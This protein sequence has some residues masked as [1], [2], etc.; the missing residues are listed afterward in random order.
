MKKN[1]G[2]FISIAA[3]AFLL[4][5]FFITWISS[6]YSFQKNASK[7]LKHSAEL[8]TL[9]F[10]SKLNSELALVRQMAR[11][12]SICQYL[13]HPDNEELRAAAYE[14]FGAYCNSFL[15]KT[16]FWVSDANLE[17]YSDMQYQY[18]V[19]PDDPDSYWYKMTM[20]ETEE[21]NFNINYNPDLNV[22][23]LW[24]NAVI[25][26]SR[27]TPVGITGTG[28]PL[29]DFINSMY[30]GLD[31]KIVMFLYNDNL[32]ITGAQDSSLVAK[33]TKLLEQLPDLSKFDL[34]PT[35]I[36]ACNTMKNEYM[37]APLSLINWHMAMKI[38]FSPKQ[39]FLHALTP[40]AVCFSILLILF[41][42]YVSSKLVSNITVLK[43]AA[44]ELSSGNADLTKR[45]K[46]A[47]NSSI[48][49][50]NLLV[51]S[52]NTFIEKLQGIVSSVKDTNV[53]LVSSGEKLKAGMEDTET[54]IS[55]IVADIQTIGENIEKQSSCVDQT[56]GA[57]NQ[58]SGNIQSLNKM[59]DTQ[60]NSVNEASAAVEQMVGNI[61]SVN[62]I[63]E[64]LA[65]QF[66]D[67][68]DKTVKSVSKQEQVNGMIIKIQ[69][70]SQMLQDANL[71][72][73]SIADQTNLLAMNAAIEAAHAGE[74]GKGFSVV[75]DEIRKLS[76][77]SSAQSKTIGN[78]LHDIED[79]ISQIVDV[80]Q[81]SHSM[82]SSVTENLKNTG[83][84]IQEIS[85]A[86][87]E[88]QVGSSQIGESLEALRDS[89]T[90]VL[91]ASQEMQI[92]SKS[93]LDEMRILEDATIAMKDKMQ[94]MTAGARKISETGNALSDISN[95]METSITTIGKQLDQFKA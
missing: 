92:G 22:T 32:E 19:N 74:A 71:V 36:T 26:N 77:N 62:S 41:A 90:E 34:V 11:S 27:G 58:I 53:E 93:I 45:I 20:Y 3:V 5:L 70:Q 75:A 60:S 67:L 72:I 65:S 66:D 6:K 57:V 13:E 40:I 29:T 86:M 89:S 15:G 37:L 4:A 52:L 64:R 10:E 25:R 73:S 24:V 68:Q 85:G 91:S 30:S 80:S 81:E 51:D 78:Q 56:S 79:S 87:Q 31:S 48:K 33:N 1:K 84:L 7:T 49:I 17:F 8:K 35:E 14:E 18:T 47:S 54:S 2:L 46:L 55:Q 16:V 43:K 38:Y 12:P 88:Q 23:L 94:E 76:E 59:I 9:E 42:F 95:E 21:Y 50:I 28:I 63:S 69:Q 83:S 61:H 82:L 44:D 39:F